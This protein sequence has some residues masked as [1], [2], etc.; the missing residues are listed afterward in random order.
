MKIAIVGTGIAGNVTGYL[1][2][3]EQLESVWPVHGS[4]LVIDQRV[5]CVAGR[6]AFLDEGMRLVCLDV[7]T[8][9]LLHEETLDKTDPTGNGL[10]EERE[11]DS[12][13]Y[14]QRIRLAGVGPAV[15]CAGLPRCGVMS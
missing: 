12:R 13:Y 15:V 5:Y 1:L 3:R 9:K 8:G 10:I 14:P 7:K 2:A 4:P 11:Y 6:S